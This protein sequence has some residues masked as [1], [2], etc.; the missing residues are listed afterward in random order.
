MRETV[1]LFR[2]YQH[3]LRHISHHMPSSDKSNHVPS[4]YP[5][6]ASM[7]PHVSLHL[8]ELRCI[9]WLQRP[10]TVEVITPSRCPFSSVHNTDQPPP[11]FCTEASDYSHLYCPGSFCGG[12]APV[13]ARPADQQPDIGPPRPRRV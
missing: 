10:P 8:A 9:A 12:A 11:L 6:Y 1:F 3:H 5:P 13:A 7:T 2:N 4:L